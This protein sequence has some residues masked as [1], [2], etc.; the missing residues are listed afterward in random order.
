MNAF[1]FSL[2]YDG[3]EVLACSSPWLNSQP[4]LVPKSFGMFTFQCLQ[5]MLLK[6]PLNHTAVCTDDQFQFLDEELWM[7]FFTAEP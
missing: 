4:S 3:T 5:H 2:L 6:L 1:R 7:A